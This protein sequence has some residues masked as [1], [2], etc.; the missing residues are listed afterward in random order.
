MSVEGNYRTL[1]TTGIL[2]AILREGN[3]IFETGDTVFS[4]CLV[5]VTS[6]PRVL[7]IGRRGDKHFCFQYLFLWNIEDEKIVS[8][9]FAQTAIREGNK[10]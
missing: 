9:N 7:P 1:I 6:Q 5:P 2:K 3:I 8:S 10:S 4:S